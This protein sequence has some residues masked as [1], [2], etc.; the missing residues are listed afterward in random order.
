[1]CSIAAL[2]EYRANAQATYIVIVPCFSVHTGPWTWKVSFQIP[3]V[4]S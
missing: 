4:G 2:L 1:M 3:D